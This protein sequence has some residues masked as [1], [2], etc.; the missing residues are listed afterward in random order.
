MTEHTNQRLQV[1]NGPDVKF[2]GRCAY[3]YS[4]QSK[5][6]DKPRWTELR[7]WETE[8]GAWIAESVGC[9]S[10]PG[11]ADL[12]DV[13]VIEQTEEGLDATGERQGEILADW[14]N[15]VMTFFGWSTVAK[16]FARKAGWEVVREVA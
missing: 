14:I 10:K 16:A 11:E 8:G 6:G 2:A 3:E 4:T 15:Q 1:N 7:L 5:A 9:S 13:L 12:R